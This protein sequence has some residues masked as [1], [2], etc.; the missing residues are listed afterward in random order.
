MRVTPS[1]VR[2]AVEA[3]SDSDVQFAINIATRIID[4]VAACDSA[5]DSDLSYE[6]LVLLEQLVAC[7]VYTLKDPLYSSKSTQNA[8][9]SFLNTK[10]QYLDTALMLDDSGCLAAMVDSAENRSK[11]VASMSW[12]G[13]RPSE[14]TPYRDRD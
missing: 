3:D 11:R 4:K 12:L 7:H 14:Q 5:A 9:A 2:E 10:T 1:E 6:D 13:K 8:S